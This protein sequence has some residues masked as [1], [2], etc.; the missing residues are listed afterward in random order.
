[1]DSLAFQENCVHNTCCQHFVYYSDEIDEFLKRVGYY[2]QC[3]LIVN[4]LYKTE[5]YAD[6][7]IYKLFLQKKEGLISS[8]IKEP[9]YL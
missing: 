3:V 2:M 6:L 4:S 5:Y 7:V 1:M 9:L 8:R